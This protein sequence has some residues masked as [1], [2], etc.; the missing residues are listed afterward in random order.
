MSRRFQARLAVVL[1]FVW[2]IAFLAEVVLAI[3]KR[4]L[5]DRCCWDKARAIVGF[6]VVTRLFKRQDSILA[7]AAII[8]VTYF[9]SAVLGLVRDR[10]LAHYFGD[11][12]QLGIFFAADRLPNLIFSIVV[13]GTL[14]SAFI[15]VFSK[16]LRHGADEAWRVASG[17]LN[18]SL[19][20]FF[21]LGLGLFWL[22]PHLARLLTIWDAKD[23]TAADY[24][25]LANLMRVMLLAQLIL[26]IS[27]FLTSVLQSYRRFLIPALSPVVYN[28]GTILGIVWL[29]P[30]WGVLAPA[31]GMVAGA[32]LHLL[33]QLPLLGSLRPRYAWG[34]AWRHPGVRE[35]LRLTPPRVLGLTASQ[36]SFLVDTMLAVSISAPAV[37]ILNFAKHLQ[38]LPVS[39]FGS[40]LAQA[41]LPTLAAYS[42]KE[43]DLFW[44]TLAT[45]LNQMFF[46]ILPLSAFLLVLKIPIIRLV[47]GAARFSWAATVGTAYTLSFF[48]LSIFAQA[49][50]YIL[51]R[52][53]YSLCDTKTPVKVSVGSLLTNVLLSFLFVR[54]WGWGVWS[55]GLSYTVGSWLNFSLLAWRLR[56]RLD[57]VRWEDVGEPFL[58]IAYAAILTATA[59]YL[60]LKLLD[61]YVFDTTRTVNLI[62]LTATVSSVGFGVY[63]FLGEIMDIKERRSIFN[64]LNLLPPPRRLL[65]LLKR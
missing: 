39:L 37:V 57:T 60:P 65:A 7:A 29:T 9:A 21:F 32:S 6:A 25:L 47:F 61:E 62:L 52:A 34:L 8:A 48:S 51:S 50:V 45:S 17:V 13:V 38:N 15:P 19:V 23:W 16:T 58:K 31:I 3:L 49:G 4:I 35:I 14:S 24:Q 12:R 1:F 43:K 44:R 20:G 33:I 53:F 63:L 28:L 36:I 11:S 26:I 59:L 54:H 46:L 10:L 40:S 64:L 27:S 41:S 55:L 18:L 30:R 5:A 42:D 2:R 56:R 22:A